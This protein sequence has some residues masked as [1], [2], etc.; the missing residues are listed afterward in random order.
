MLP[1]FFSLFTASGSYSLVAMLGLFIVV[2][3]LVSEPGLE[4]T[5]T[6]IVAIP[7][8]SSCGSPALEHR[9]SSFGAWAELLCGMWDLSG[10]GI[11]PMSSALAGRFFTTEPQ[12]KPE[13]LL[14]LTIP[15][16]LCSAVLSRSVVSDSAAPWIVAR[17]APLLMGFF[18]QEY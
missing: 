12:E 15:L 13:P 7:G 9:L 17:Q 8:L 11:E 18:G 2:A 4:G 10:P 16:M 6:S 5:Q 1:G 14:L 3:S